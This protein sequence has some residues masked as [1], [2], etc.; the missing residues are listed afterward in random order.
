M[1]K[2]SFI[3]SFTLALLLFCMLVG[4]IHLFA[5]RF[6][7]GDIYPAYSSLRSDP[8]GTRVLYESLG[9]FKDIRVQRNYQ[10]LSSLKF[11][12]HTTFL[13]LAAEAD[14]TDLMPAS[15]NEVFQ[16]LTD[17]GGRLVLS[18]L[19]VVEDVEKKTCPAAEE[20]DSSD[21][22]NLPPGDDAPAQ[23]PAG[24][25]KPERSGESGPAE[26]APPTCKNDA[27]GNDFVSVREQWGLE[28]NFNANLPVKDEKYLAL[29]ALGLRPDLPAAISW[30]SNLYFDLLSDSWRMVYS[31]DGRPVIV[32]RPMGKGTL[33]LC[34]DSFFISNEALRSDRHPRLLAWLLGRPAEIVFEETHFGVFKQTGVVDLL[35]HYRFTWFLAALFVPALLF[36]WKNAVYFVPPGR[37]D[38]SPA[39][40]VLS[41]KDSASGLIALLRRN[42]TDNAILQVCCREWEQTFRKDKRISNN[43]ALLIE[44]VLRSE[45]S[46]TKKNPDPAAGYRKISNALKGLGIGSKGSHIR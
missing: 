10:Q 46:S 1:R 7:G 36:V 11:E 34:A 40:D 25:N 4:V 17:S 13:Y 39:A 42:F 38:N 14:Q 35:R 28:L 5:M 21:D 29:H 24:A 33:V 16:R 22:E 18:F 19:P 26:N 45:P 2:N 12:P 31:V 32:E 15:L 27:G 3:R 41:E 44:N 20:E 6:K 43:A 23:Q 37:S 8:L 9:A 30:H